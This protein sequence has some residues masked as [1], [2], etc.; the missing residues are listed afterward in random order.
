MVIPAMDFAELININLAVIGHFIAAY[1][2]FYNSLKSVNLSE[3]LFSILKILNIIIGVVL[4]VFCFIYMLAEVVGVDNSLKDGA[5]HI[6][7]VLSVVFA[8][9]CY[10]HIQRKNINQ[11]STFIERNSGNGVKLTKNKQGEAVMANSANKDIRH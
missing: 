10:L 2:I 11:Q 8:F 3:I 9:L 6:L 4:F 7:L 5:E 1:L